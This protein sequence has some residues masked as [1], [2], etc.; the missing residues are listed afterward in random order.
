MSIQPYK[1]VYIRVTALNNKYNLI[2]PLYPSQKFPGYWCCRKV[3]DN[4]LS[5]VRES[6]IEH[7]IMSDDVERINKYIGKDNIS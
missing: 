5:Y 6:V 1:L 3:K 2:V 4:T 7:G